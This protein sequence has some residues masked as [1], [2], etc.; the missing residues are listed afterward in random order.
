MERRQLDQRSRQDTQPI[1]ARVIHGAAQ[2]TVVRFP[3]SPRALTH[4]HPVF[5]C[6]SVCV[7]LLKTIPASTFCSSCVSA[8]FH[9]RKVKT[10]SSDV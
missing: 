4:T 5:V 3:C 1:N 10:R 9:L 6:M 7:C 2:S 8:K